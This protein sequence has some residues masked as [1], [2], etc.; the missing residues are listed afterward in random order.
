MCKN[1]RNK[2]RRGIAQEKRQSLLNRQAGVGKKIPFCRKGREEAENKSDEKL[3][4][5]N[6]NTRK[7]GTSHRR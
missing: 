4:S 6:K 1:V 3:P 2:R 7:E 5:L